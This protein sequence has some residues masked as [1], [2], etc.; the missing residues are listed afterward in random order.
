MPLETAELERDRILRYVSERL[1]ATVP[2][3]LARGN[4]PWLDFLEGQ[5][6][7]E[8]TRADA[9][10]ALPLI[11]IGRFLAFEEIMAAVGADRHCDIGQ[12]DAP[13]RQR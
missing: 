12:G 10:A 9:E 3:I 7:A 11:D 8:I 6:S 5:F 1:Y 4:V 2:R 13:T